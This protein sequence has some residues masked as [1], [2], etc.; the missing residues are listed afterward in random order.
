MADIFLSYANEDE[1]HAR[2]LAEA[3]QREGWSVWWD[4]HIP[5]GR[6]WSEVI[7]QE[8]GKAGCVVVLWS[9]HAVRSQWVQ[10]E[11]RE[12]LNRHVLVP[13]IGDRDVRLPLE[14]R[15]VQAAYLHGWDLDDGRSE[16]AQLVAS[17]RDVLRRGTALPETP[18]APVPPPPRSAPKWPW[19]AG[20]GALV[21]LAAI[22]AWL[23]PKPEPPQP[24]AVDTVATVATMDI[25]DTVDTVATATLQTDTATTTRPLIRV[26]V[27]IPRPITPKV[28]IGTISGGGEGCVAF[29]VARDL[30]LTDPDCIPATRARITLSFRSGTHT[31]RHTV[32]VAER[33]PTY[34]LLRLSPAADPI[35][36]VISLETRNVKLDEPVRV[37]ASSS[38]SISCTELSSSSLM[39]DCGTTPA[40]GSPVVGADGLLLGMHRRPRSG[41][42][43]QG[44]KLRSILQSSDAL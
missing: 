5:P 25:V 26:P 6:S 4:H 30:A 9:K 16:Y 10:N 31:H 11:A 22:A 28:A 41:T 8:I 32:A 12:G 13:V 2:A 29:L 20:L 42:V 24:I 19:I 17:I 3:L 44:I 34:V 14:F 33:E 36:P 7:E 39:Y 18:A 37:L 43:M 21:L 1:V 35:Y 40:P 23:W 38:R 15:H 27:P